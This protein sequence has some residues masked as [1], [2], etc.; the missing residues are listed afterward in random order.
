MSSQGA[1]DPA[2]TPEGKLPPFEVAKALAFKQCLDAIEE[3]T[4]KTCWELTGMSKKDFTAKQLTKMGGK[5]GQSVTGR[6]VQKHWAKAQLDGNWFP[7]KKSGNKGGRPPQITQAQKQAI[8][9][10]AMELKDEIIAPTPEKIR[11]CLPKKTINKGTGEPMSDWSIINIFKTMCY[12]EA[13]DDPWQFLT[14]L[15]QD[16]LADEM[17]PARVDTAKY[18]LKNL[19]ESNAWNFIAIDPCLSL[20]PRKQEK[21]DLLKIAAMGH[22]KW[23]SDG[24]RRKGKNLRAPATAKTQKKDCAV[25]PWTPIFTRGCLKIVVLTERNAKL[26]SSDTIAEF[27]QHQLQP[28]LDS[29]KKQWCWANTPKVILHDKASYYVDSIVNQLNKTFAKGLRAGGFKSWCQEDTRWLGSHLGDFYPHESVISHVRRLLSTKFAKGSLWETPAQFAARMKKV[30]DHMN[31]E[32][33]DCLERLGKCLLSRAEE[34]KRR[35]G[36]RIPK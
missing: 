9:S 19:T 12:D 27:V 15:Q 21:A 11:I 13:E 31:N 2:T 25:V 8:A 28:C 24:S 18:V 34:L 30:E 32:M 5:K 14:S 26:N 36:E 33:P 6:A 20:L 16:C 17:K 29:M 35:G 4:K 10:K 23:M 22:S 3:H 1:M 7:G